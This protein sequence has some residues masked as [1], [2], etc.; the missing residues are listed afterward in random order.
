MPYSYATE[1]PALVNDD[2]QRIIVAVALKLQRTL[3]AGATIRAEAIMT[4][5]GQQ[6]GCSSNWEQLAVVDRLV[7]IG[8][9]REIALADEVAA[10][11]RL[12]EAGKMLS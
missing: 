6:Y 11:H 1:R 8:C 4:M 12:F 10:Q 3:T 7:E 9:L 5:A 2:G